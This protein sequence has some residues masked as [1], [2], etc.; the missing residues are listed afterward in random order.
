MYEFLSSNLKKIP[1]FEPGL[2]LKLWSTKIGKCFSKVQRIKDNKSSVGVI[3]EFL[4]YSY[5]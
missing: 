2:F 1:L 4:V 5:R 3:N